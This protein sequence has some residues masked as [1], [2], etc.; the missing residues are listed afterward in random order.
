MLARMWW[1]CKM[2]QS[3]WRRVWKF[4]TK[5][6]LLFPQNPAITLP[7]ISNELKSNVH[8]E[9]NTCIFMASSF[10]I[11]KTM[12]ATKLSFSR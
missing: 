9:T 2:M 11:A 6:H 4:L 12:T 3:L 1:E 8:T 7:S 5:P 10:M